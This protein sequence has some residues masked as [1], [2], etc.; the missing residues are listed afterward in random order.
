MDALIPDV[1]RLLNDTLSTE[2]AVLTS[3]T[4]ALDQLSAL[5]HFSLSLLAVA[6]GGESQGLKLA[7]AAYLKNFIRRSTD[8]KLSFF[9]I[10]TFR[11]QLAQATLR[12]EPAVLKV[13]V[14]ALRW[15]V[16]KDFVKDYSWPE[17]V[18]NLRTAIQ[19]SNL[20][21]Q[22]MTSEWSTVNALTVLQ[23]ILRQFQYFL[24][25]KVQNEP[26]PVQLEIIAKDILVPLQA[27]FHGFVDKVLSSQNSCHD[28]LRKELEQSILII[29]KCLYFSMRSYMPSEL[30]PILPSF[31]LDLFRILDMLSL[32]SASEDGSLLLLKIAKRSLIF[33]S[34]L[35]TRH[36]KHVDRLI[37]SIV[38]SSFKVAKQSAYNFG[39]LSERIISLAFDVIS[40]VLETGPGWRFVSPHFSSLL[41]SAVFPALAL[42]QKD[43]VEWEEDTEEYIRKNLPSDIDEI[44]GWSEDLFTARKSAINLLGTIAM[45]KGPHLVASNSKRK[46]GDKS[47]GKQ[48]ESSTGELLVIPFLSKFP[49][50]CH[51]DKASSK[52]VQNYYGVLMAYGGLQAFLKERNSEYTSSLVRNRVLPL[53]SSCPF[54]PYLVA[55]ANWL[56]GQ[57]SPCLPEA[58]SSDVYDSLIKALTF[59]EINCINCYPVRASAARAIVVL[60][61]NEYVPPDWL[62]FLQVVVNR[63]TNGDENE[64]S[65][66]FHLL[67][68]AVEAGL[69]VISHQVPMLLSSVVGAIAKHFPSIPDPWPQVVERGFAALSAII[70]SWEALLVDQDPEHNDA[71]WQSDQASIAKSFSSLLQQ[72]WQ[73]PMESNVTTEE[74]TSL[75]PS[76][77]DDIS[78]LLGLILNSAINENEIEE[79]KVPEL[80]A[81]WAELIADWHAWEETE[82]IAVF[83]CIHKIV[84]LHNRCDSTNFFTRRIASRLS[85]GL[86]HSIIADISSF[87]AKG[88]MAYP[89]AT[90]RAASC[91]HAILNTSQFSLQIEDVKQSITTSF[92]QAAFS[93]YKD[94]QNKP[95]ALWKPL[96]LVI[97]SCYIRYPE[98]VE[99]VLE[100]DEVNDFIIFAHGLA[101]ISSNTF[102]SGLSSVS[103]IKLAVISLGKLVVQFLAF[104]S[105]HNNH[106]LPE[107]FASLMEAYIHLKEV[108]EAEA[109]ESDSE[110]IDV[111]SEEETSYDEDSEDDGDLEET[112]E[113]FLERY[114]KAADELSEVAEGDMED[115]VQDLELGFLEKIDLREEILLLLRRHHQV[116]LKSQAVS[117]NLVQQ[118]MNLFPECTSLQVH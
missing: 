105:E 1:S 54:V 73:M 12:A 81:V 13:L 49:M 57:L 22:G 10:H 8:A 89:S 80:L 62:S 108:E 104:P 113:E 100:K 65:F 84:N 88:L 26:V 2:K 115:G 11:N 74:S 71:E 51:E 46:K 86:E 68:S 27:T 55:T 59:P 23:T 79:L 92:T 45:S 60:L 20:I 61:E 99:R 110:D 93:H 76:C 3:T 67:G 98:I 41:D 94:L 69:S 77:L 5:P 58:M 34:G 53:Y 103:E 75:P 56:L 25:P 106:I 97:A 78:T 101:Q 95:T 87:I 85:P 111:E 109:Q 118:I 31:C 36:R 47:K 21:I 72:A 35:V 18:P 7:A 102:K 48:Q 107:C 117:P 30:G 37:P 9:E 96:L 70:K 33:F 82:D 43:I 38:D 16:L 14:D 50:P 32:D 90:R 28:Q 91:V 40:H 112:H 64:L 63:I 42:N 116:L 19:S 39:Y 6:T 29:C 52:I 24:N 66:L 114:A 44:S 17:L 4:D 15:I 83:D